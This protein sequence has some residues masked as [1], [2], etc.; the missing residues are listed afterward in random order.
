MTEKQQQRYI[1]D[2]KDI[3]VIRHECIHSENTDPCPTD[4]P[5]FDAK[6]VD[7]TLDP[8]EYLRSRPINSNLTLPP[9]LQDYYTMKSQKTNKPVSTLVLS[10]L[11]ALMKK[12]VA[13]DEKRV[14][15]EI[16]Y[17]RL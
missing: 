3:L 12:R 14:W 8:E 2:E 6:K 17:E 7:C 11:T 1:I 4:C 16:E 5:Y 15:K 13:M 9:S 10:D